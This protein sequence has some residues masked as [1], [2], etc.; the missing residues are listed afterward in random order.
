MTRG[1][2]ALKGM[3]R[4]TGVNTIASTI[5]TSTNSVSQTSL[6]RSLAQRE[7]RVTT[8]GMFI[9]GSTLYLPD[10][11]NGPQHSDG[12]ERKQVQQQIP[13]TIARRRSFDRRNRFRVSCRALQPHAHSPKLFSVEVHGGAI[14]NLA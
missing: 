8:L 6:R 13:A 4:N 11:C 1:V 9:S 14:L 7:S 3:I 12:Q 5:T 2:C 10:H